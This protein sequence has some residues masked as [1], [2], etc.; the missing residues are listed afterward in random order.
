M[1]SLLLIIL[2]NFLKKKSQENFVCLKTVQKW[3]RSKKEELKNDPQNS[4][5]YYNIIKNTKKKSVQNLNFCPSLI[6]SQKKN[7]IPT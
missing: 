2:K 7:I 4:I 3:K 6:D 1:D 5:T